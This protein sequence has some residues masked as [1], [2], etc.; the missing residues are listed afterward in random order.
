MY[1]ITSDNGKWISIISL[2]FSYKT[3]V[4][5]NLLSSFS[6]IKSHDSP[7]EGYSI[8]SLYPQQNFIEMV[9]DVN[10][11]F[12]NPWYICFHRVESVEYVDKRC[13]CQ[14]WILSMQITKHI[15]LLLFKGI[16]VIALVMVVEISIHFCKFFSHWNGVLS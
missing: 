9:L 1:C 15:L 12:L 7:F 16:Y 5:L 10:Q 4:K 6:N 11:M 13:S 3:L 2:N 8:S 14:S